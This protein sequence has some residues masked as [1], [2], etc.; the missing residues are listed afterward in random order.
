MSSLRAVELVLWVAGIAL[1]GGYVAAR[2]AFEGARADGIAAYR[3]AQAAASGPETAP[4]LPA[5]AGDTPGVDRSLWSRQRI[6]A[7]LVAAPA[8]GPPLGV[9]HIPRLGLEVPVR[10]GTGEADLDSGAAHIRGTAGLTASGNIGIAAHRDGFFRALQDVA[11][12]DEIVLEAGGLARTFRVVDL[13]IVPPGETSVLAP[14]DETAVTL[15]TCYPFWF[16]G[17]AP[18]RYVVRAALQDAAPGAVH[19]SPLNPI[20]STRGKDD[21]E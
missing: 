21:E 19:E 13:A 16:A 17:H 14:A 7:F 6:A 8:A 11:I 3:Q 9:L 2:T 12:D 10:P 15:V 1:L 18:R 20:A 5:A 4:P